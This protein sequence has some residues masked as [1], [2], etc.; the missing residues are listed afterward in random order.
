VVGCVPDICIVPEERMCGV[1][2]VTQSLGSPQELS[3]MLYDA[4]CTNHPD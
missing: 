3:A 1:K 2:L 4:I